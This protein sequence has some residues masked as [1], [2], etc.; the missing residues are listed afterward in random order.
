VNKVKRQRAAL[1]EVATLSGWHNGDGL[2]AK[3]FKRIVEEIFNKLNP[4][5]FSIA[6]HPVRRNSPVEDIK[7]LLETGLDDARSIGIYGI[8]G[9]GKT[10]VAKAIYNHI[11]NQ[12]EGNAF[13]ENFREVSVK[14]LA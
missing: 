10:T 14:D 9:I 8:V 1:C 5:P 12:H 7:S 13:I 3:F 11:I 4:T 2:K 6:K